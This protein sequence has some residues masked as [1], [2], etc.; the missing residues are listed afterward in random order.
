MELD[1]QKVLRQGRRERDRRGVLLCWL[2]V[3]VSERLRTT[4]EGFF[5]IQNKSG[6]S[7]AW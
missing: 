5:S 3:E 6:R 2:Y 1:A 7:A 4:S